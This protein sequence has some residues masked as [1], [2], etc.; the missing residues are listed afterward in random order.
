MKPLKQIVQVIAFYFIAKHI[1]NLILSGNYVIIVIIL[2]ALPI[3]LWMSIQQKF[4]LFSLSIFIAFNFPDSFFLPM[5][6]WSEIIAPVMCLFLFLE[7]LNNRKQIFSGK[8]ALFLLAIVILI[9]W[10]IAGYIRNPVSGMLTFGSSFEG[11]GLRRFY[12]IFVGVTIFFTSFWFFRYKEIDIQKWLLLLIVASSIIGLLRL[13]GFYNDIYIPL[14]GQ[15]F[16]NVLESN[17]RGGYVRIG[18]LGGMAALGI[19]SLLTLFYKKRINLLGYVLFVW[20]LFLLLSSGGRAGSYGIGLSIIVYVFF[21]NR[22]F[23]K[24][25]VFAIALFFIFMTLTS[26][27]HRMPDQAQRFASI[28]NVDP[29]SFEFRYYKSLYMWEIFKANPIFGKGIGYSVIDESDSFFEMVEAAESYRKDIESQIMLGGHG[30]YFSIL[31]IFGIG[32]AFFFFVMLFGST[33]YACRIFTRKSESQ[34]DT[35][36]ALFAFVY[37]IMLVVF[38]MTSGTGYSDMKLW[39]FGGV[40]A[41]LLAK[42]RFQDKVECSEKEKYIVERIIWSE[43]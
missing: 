6:E 9:V 1:G 35:K 31:S 8:A 25:L 34:N 12:L 11:G 32:G 21:I 24:P 38:L 17:S 22:K 37:L 19:S 42:D 20:F 27:F 36:L 30:S 29:V 13:I 3:F 15:M 4:I 23:L 40:V 43:G 28:R 10:T 41:G 14:L 7:L 39:F 2:V 18:G 5:N 26:Y 33:Y 16:T